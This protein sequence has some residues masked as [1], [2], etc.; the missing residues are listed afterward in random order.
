M[1][2]KQIRKLAYGGLLIA[3][4]LVATMFLQIPN[5]LGGY[6]N[7]GDGVI[8][9]SA[10]L[11]GP[12]AGVIGATGAGLADFI[13]GYGVYIP[14]TIVI[15]GLMGLL[16][17]LGLLW[18]RKNSYTYKAFLFLLCEIIMVAGYFAFESFF[19]GFGVSL[20]SLMPNVIQGIAGLA[21]GLAL[22]PLMERIAKA[23]GL[24]LK[25]QKTKRDKG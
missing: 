20:P 24:G 25:G 10:L 11:L 9:A 22:S 14:A 5:G 1:T 21:V 16:A 17:G 19:F 4:V 23:S 13:L 6:I 12:F 15:K 3:F 2:R 7:L 8:F 18:G